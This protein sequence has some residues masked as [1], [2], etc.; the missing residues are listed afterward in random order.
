MLSPAEFIGSGATGLS[1]SVLGTYLLSRRKGAETLDAAQRLE[2]VKAQEKIE[3]Q[4]RAL[5]EALR[6]PKRT[7]AEEHH[8]SAARASLEKLPT[9]CAEVLRHLRLHENLTYGRMNPSCPSG[10]SFTNHRGFL[11]L[12]AEE[13]LV[14]KKARNTP[15]GIEWDYRIAPG[16]QAT[17]DELLYSTG[18]QPTA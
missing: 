6:K 3:E 18:E 7:R 8:Y 16:M 1:L 10:M 5:D 17:L 12:C 4:Q 11:D 13:H 9:E 14:D 15:G 2:A